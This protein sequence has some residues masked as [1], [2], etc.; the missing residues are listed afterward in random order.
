MRYSLEVDSAA[1]R[2]CLYWLTPEPIRAGLQGW[3]S[4]DTYG[5]LLVNITSLHDHPL[6]V[7]LLD[8]QDKMVKQVKAAEWRGGVLLSETAEVLHASRS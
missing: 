2:V 3:N 8:S 4:L 7:Q 5:T 1:L 6:L